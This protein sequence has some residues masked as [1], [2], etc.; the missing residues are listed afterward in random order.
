MVENGRADQRMDGVKAEAKDKV[1]QISKKAGRNMPQA[2]ATGA[3]LVLLVLASMIFNPQPFIFLVVIFMLIALWEL[4]VDF[5]VVGIRIPLVALWICSAA[6]LLSVYYL[7]AKDHLAVA[8]AGIT[9]TFLVTVIFASINRKGSERA[10]EAALAKVNSG[11]AGE[12]EGQTP[13]SAVLP[14]GQ[15]ERYRNILATCLAVF[16]V[17]FLASFIVLPMTMKHYLAHAIMVIFVPAL[18]D[19]GGLL[20][21]AWLGKHKLSPRIS[22]KKS[23]EG[24][25]G[26]VLF[27]LAGTLIIGACT[28][29][30]ATWHSKWFVLVILGLVIGLVGLFGD[31]SASIIKRDLG[32]KDMGHLL[33]GHGGVLDRVD[34][35]LMCAP[36]TFFIL[37]AAGL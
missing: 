8:L 9:A 26:S 3:L 36:V 23:W 15:P 29:A 4:R 32:I 35:I 1:D 27:T 5:A 6:Q 20:F 24:L 2:I 31:L 21:G 16:Y 33:K 25:L 7:P 30:S 22:P 18:G 37:V 12:L 28:Y 19:T 13:H 10:A 34:S 11:L 14:D 17:P